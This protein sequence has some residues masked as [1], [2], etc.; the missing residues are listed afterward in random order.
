MVAQRNPARPLCPLTLSH[1]MLRKFTLLLTCLFLAGGF[2]A[3]DDSDNDDHDNTDDSPTPQATTEQALFEQGTYAV[4]HQ[5]T[6]VS[7]T[8]PGESTARELPVRVW[9]PSP[10]DTTGEPAD[11]KVGGFVELTPLY[12]LEATAPAT[13][14]FPLAIYSH[15]S[16]GD[17]LLAYPY[18]ELLASRGWIVISAS[19][20]GNTALDSL[21]DKLLPFDE[22]AV[23]RVTDISAMIDDADNGFGID[24]LIEHIDTD[25]IFL[26][27]HSFGAYTTLVA[28]GATLDYDSLLASCG[29][30]E[31]D[32]CVYLLNDDVEQ[33]IRDGLGDD[34]I[35]AIA[36]QA[37]A[38]SNA[39][40]DDG[41]ADISIPTMLMSG[42]LDKTTPEATQTL[43]V[44]NGLDESEDLW[45]DLPKGAHFTFITICDD[46][47]RDLLLGFQPDAIEDGCGDEFISTLDAV[48]I[49]RAY[50]VAFAE[51]HVLGI[52][53]W[54]DVLSGA[55]L[56][57]RFLVSTHAD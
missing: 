6:S 46:L 29:G 25:D 26:F 44:W 15:G 17:N 38:V 4:G 40:A 20:V 33:A 23:K 45:I 2:V 28:G 41:Y 30:R 16:G 14:K 51:L 24:A 8:P 11:Y 34:R 53:A 7:Y 19:H 42:Q 47:S 37:P 55:P 52:D 54:S 57:E 32:D 18:A 3:C 39:F 31:S 50:V 21:T 22:V 49:L 56:D 10:A 36:P 13:G 35:D 9:Y 48:P 43:P 1:S 27:G 12:A 5:Q